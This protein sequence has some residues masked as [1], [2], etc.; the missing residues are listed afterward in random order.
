MPITANNN[1][2]DIVGL[3]FDS[4]FRGLNVIEDT[5]GLIEPLNLTAPGSE[6]VFQ[7]VS[8]NYKVPPKNETTESYPYIEFWIYDSEN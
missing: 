4:V 6:S 8:L 1:S 2:S 7:I 5:G 3:D